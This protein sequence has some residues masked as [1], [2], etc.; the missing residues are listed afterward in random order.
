MGQRRLHR[1]ASM[2]IAAMF[3]YGASDAIG[4]TNHIVRFGGVYGDAF[5]PNSLS[6]SVNDTIT[7]IGDFVFHTVTSTTI[8][9]GAA[10][11]Y[12]ASGSSFAYVVRTP[13]TYNYQCDNHYIYGMVG[14]FTASATGVG[15][16]AP[17]GRI[18]FFRLEQ[19]FPNP[20]NP[21]T[22]I[23]YAVP[24]RSSV[25][26]KV[27]NALGGEVAQLV[28]GLQEAGEHRIS[29][30]GSGLSSGVYFYR[31]QARESPQSPTGGDGKLFTATRTL[32]LL[33]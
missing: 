26:L 17:P 21:T 23:A 32:L 4:G 3:F 29:F 30:D 1:A 15:E 12:H 13:G 14:S 25:S 18:V 20:F 6:V 27:Y 31:L 9:A 19:N 2:I 33:K 8:P 22:M 24:S 5:S 28:S 11:F 10:P 16:D 7:W